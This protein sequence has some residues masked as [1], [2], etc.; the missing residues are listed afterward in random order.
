MSAFFDNIRS[1]GNI[2]RDDK[3]ARVESFDYF[4]VRDIETGLD[5]NKIYAG[6]LWYSHRLIGDKRHRYSG[7]VGCAEEYLLDHDGARIGIDPDFHCAP[8]S[9]W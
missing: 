3:I 6:F 2:S 4:V 1:K 7:T 9:H 5:K 8:L